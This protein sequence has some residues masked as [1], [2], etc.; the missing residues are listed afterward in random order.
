MAIFDFGGV[1]VDWNPR[2][3]YRKLIPDP[4]EME[5]FLAEV[6]TRDWHVVQDHG[7]DPTEA[8]QRLQ[9]R[10]PGKEALIAAFY[11]RF[12]EMN[13]HAFPDMAALV[14]RLH[15]AGTPLYLLS[16]A[17]N[18]LDPWLRGP[19]SERHPFLGLFR[20]YVVSGLVGHSKPDAAIYE[21]VC[22]TGG[23]E[24]ADAVF[25]DDVLANVEG[26]RAVGM[27]AIHHRSAEQTAAELRALGFAV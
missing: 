7:G 21:L 12:D 27:A 23:F 6:T 16:N 19:A 8:T 13:A 17:P 26:A 24:P 15:A 18:L 3:L 22:R 25:I 4:A 11:D 9:A 2:H 5:R 20:D 14:E 10:H 1:L